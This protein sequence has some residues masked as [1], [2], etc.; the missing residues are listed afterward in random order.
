MKKHRIRFGGRSR[1]LGKG[2]ANKTPRRFS[3]S[4]VE[5]LELRA[6]L[7]AASSVD[8]GWQ[9]TSAGVGAD[10][11]ATL[12]TMRSM[13]ASCSSSASSSTSTSTQ[14][15]TAGPAASPLATT[16]FSTLDDTTGSPVVSP[17]V[18]TAVA[19]FRL[20]AE[21]TTAAHN[22]ITHVQPGQDFV[23]AAIV[24]DIRDPVHTNAGV[25]A[26]FMNVSYSSALA[27]ITSQAPVNGADGALTFGDYFKN[28]LLAGDASSAGQIVGAGSSSLQFAGS[29]TGDVLLWRITVHANA[30]GDL[31]FTPSF[32]SAQDHDSSFIDPPDT[33][34]TDDIQFTPTTV[35]IFTTPTVSITPSVSHNEGDAGTTPYVFTVSLSAAVSEQATVLYS[36]SNGT[37]QANDFTAQSGTITFAP[38]DASELITINVN[39]DTTVEPDEAFSVNLSSPVGATLGAAITGVGTIVNDDLPILGISPVSQNEGDAANNMVFSVTLSAASSTPVVVAFHTVDGTATAGSDYTATSGSITFAA[40]STTT[41]LITVPILGDTNNE[42]NENFHLV[43]TQPANAVFDASEGDALGTLLNDDGAHITITQNVT[44][45]EG[46]SGT[47]AY[48]FTVAINSLPTDTATVQFSTANG[49]TNPAT[50]GSDYT[51]TSGTLTFN[52]EGAL[53]QDITVLV[54]GDT[55]NEADE[56]FVVNLSNAVNATLTNSSGTGTITNDDAAPTLSFAASPVSVTEPDSGT[57]PLVFTVNLSA[58]SGQTVTAQFVTNNGTASA[59]DNDFTALPTSTLTFA[60]GET[61]KLITVLVNGDTKNEADESFTLDLFN[62][63]NAGNATSLAT[64]LTATGTII[65]NDAVPTLTLTG[66]SHNEGNSAATGSNYFFSA[67]LSAASGQ[68]ITVPFTTADGTATAADGDYTPTSGTITFLPGQTVQR[69]TVFAPG[70]T[71]AELDETFKVN[72]SPGTNVNLGNDT[73]NGTIVNDDNLPTVGIVGPGPKSEGNSGTTDFVF[74]VSLSTASGQQVTVNFSTADGTATT[75]NNDY[76]GQS[77]VVTFAA[78]ETSKLITVAVN[79]D[80][81]NE[82]DETFNVT[83]NS[84]AGALLS[85]SQG[86]A[87]GLILNDDALPGLSIANVSQAEGDSGTT[88]FVFPVTLSAISGQQVTVAF[89]TADGTAT[90]A[91]NDYNATSGTLTF[92]PGVG[93]QNITVQVKGDL[94]IESNETFLV[95]L[96]SPTLAT[97][98]DGQATGTIQSEGSDNITFT[99]STISGFMFVD[100]DNGHD[101]DAVEKGLSGQTVRITGTSSASGA[102]VN[103]TTTTGSNGAYSFGSLEPGTYQ[104]TFTQP[105]GGYFP[106]TAQSGESHATVL[107][108]GQIG[109]SVTIP[110]L[111]GVQSTE[112]NVFVR[113]L[114]AGAISQRAFVV[115]NQGTATTSASPQATALASTLSATT[116]NDPSITQNGS[117]VTIHGTSGDDQFEVVAGATYVVKINGIEHQFSSANV[118]KIEIDGGGGYDTATLTG[119]SGDDVADFGLRSGTLTGA[120]YAVSLSN[121][122]SINVNGGGGH[123]TAA[124]HDTALVDHLNADGDNVELSNDFDDVTSLLAFAQV[125][126]TSTTGADTAHVGTIDFALERLGNWTLV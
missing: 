104:V 114:T 111:G 38:G 19:Q 43:L 56:T 40:G 22:P 48:V 54:N 64:K 120:G 57:T 96:T 108:N 72:L 98:A 58:A 106:A 125:Q 87:Q 110:S 47:T 90:T 73:A 84:P 105:T 14:S 99:P 103:T 123:D 82:G 86:S 35:H 2:R 52:T 1:F 63:T 28:G 51:A 94:L 21:D 68:T 37:A 91:G 122:A 49:S 45:A 93:T 121:V 69:I 83:L 30:T 70:D 3:L 71:K 53:T 20:E 18:S 24:K 11:Y 4:G 42:P 13:L 27:S 92:A 102:V 50:A 100:A 62:S 10:P 23:L 32:D 6:L 79:G 77:G 124:L 115:S 65:N 85:G 109:F 16:S 118:S 55:L 17:L 7:T 31:T 112:D 29:G 95:N 75:T 25:W 41:Q 113:G 15:S 117:V 36:T 46:N 97:L 66:D 61:Q 81:R 76:I 101:R 116:N 126:A 89:S 39:G 33:F 5:H 107:S 78:N 8:P 34:T 60:P 74:T 59:A 119:S 67:T 9:D 26:A 80:T 44:H 88:N 12:P